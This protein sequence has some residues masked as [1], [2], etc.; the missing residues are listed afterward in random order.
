MVVAGG[1]AEGT[2]QLEPRGDARRAVLDRARPLI[3]D[4]PDRA[5]ARVPADTV[6][7]DLPGLAVRLDTR[8]DA[9]RSSPPRSG[10]LRHL[11]PAGPPADGAR[12]L[13]QAPGRAGEDP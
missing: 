10:A 9:D 6:A 3:K 8:R 12:G 1:L 13:D 5:R 4:R 2:D 7:G 11:G